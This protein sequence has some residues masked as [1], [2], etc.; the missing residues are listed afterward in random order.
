MRRLLPEILLDAL[1]QTVKA[2][3][4][5]KLN[6]SGGPKAGDDV[7]PVECYQTP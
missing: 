4:V 3:D 6:L 7:R 5:K 2:S 1:S